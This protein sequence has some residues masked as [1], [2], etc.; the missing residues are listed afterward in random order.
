[1]LADVQKQQQLFG[2][3]MQHHKV[4]IN[5]PNARAA[6]QDTIGVEEDSDDDEKLSAKQPDLDTREFKDCPNFKGEPAEWDSWSRAFTTGAHRVPKVQ[7]AMEDVLKQ[8]GDVDD[9]NDLVVDK[10]IIEEQRKIYVTQRNCPRFSKR[11]KRT[12]R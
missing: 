1:M 7:R 8:A 2:Q 9:L 5:G 12:R 3:T 11:W 10:K 6:Q 4:L